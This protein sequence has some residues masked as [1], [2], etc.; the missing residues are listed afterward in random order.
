MLSNNLES[1]C[2]FYQKFSESA[3]GTGLHDKSEFQKE[4][5]RAVHKTGEILASRYTQ[6]KEINIILPNAQDCTVNLIINIITGYQGLGCIKIG[7][8]AN[9]RQGKYYKK[10]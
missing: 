2:L 4:Y 6:I 3:M 9:F 7:C 8:S 5:K 10:I 1:T